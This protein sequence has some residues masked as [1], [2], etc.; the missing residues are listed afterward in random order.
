MKFCL[1]ALDNVLHV[2]LL[3]FVSFFEI[4]RNY[5]KKP[6]FVV[7]SAHDRKDLNLLK[8]QQNIDLLQRLTL[9]KC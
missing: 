1:G 4:L 8:I 3:K 9:K 7:T 6:V 5:A 2:I